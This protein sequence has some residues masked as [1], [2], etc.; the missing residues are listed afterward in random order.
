MEYIVSNSEIKAATLLLSCFPEEFS[1][2]DEA[3][4][5]LKTH[6]LDIVSESLNDCIDVNDAFSK[7]DY[8]DYEAVYSKLHYLL[9]LYLDEFDLDFSS[10]DIIDILSDYDYE[11]EHDKY[12]E[13][14][15]EPEYDKDA[16]S[17]QMMSIDQ[18]DDLFDRS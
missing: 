7:A 13:N 5:A 18:I 14:S 10:Y 4:E 15:Y 6:V 2:V 1:G 11:Y 9:E 8:Q 17:P 12:I 16:Y 3:I